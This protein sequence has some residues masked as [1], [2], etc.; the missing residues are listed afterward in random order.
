MSDESLARIRPVDRKI[1][2]PIPLKKM[3]ISIMSEI[4]TVRHQREGG[5]LT[6]GDGKHPRQTDRR[7][8]EPRVAI[9]IL[10]AGTSS[11]LGRPKQLL[12]LDGEPLIRWT[13]RHAI[14]SLCERLF[15]SWA[16][17]ATRSPRPP[18]DSGQRTVINLDFAQG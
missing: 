1:S 17:G 9:V 16:A 15:S 13:V 7:V 14:A 6:Q 10:A 11:R 5:P 12:E 3:A 2:A 18:G 8:N 4:I